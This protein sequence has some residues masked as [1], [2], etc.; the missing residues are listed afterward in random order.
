M[1]TFSENLNLNIRGQMS[2]TDAAFLV[3]YKNY[4][5]E[6]INIDGLQKS[7]ALVNYQQN[8]WIIIKIASKCD[9]LC[10]LFIC[11]V[12]ENFN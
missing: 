12:I 4:L 6:E 7:P 5:F 3:A 9:S 1:C 2:A 8:L 10:T 11:N